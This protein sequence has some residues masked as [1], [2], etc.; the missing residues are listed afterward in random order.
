MPVTV[1]IADPHATDENFEAVFSYFAYVD[2]TFSTYKPTS[3]IMR[4]NRGEIAPADYT[5]DMKEVLELSEKT[6][7][8]TDGFFD[9]R[10]PGGTLDPSGLVKGWAIYH[11][12]KLL[13]LRGIST[14]FIDAG[15]D[16]QAEGN[17]WKIGIKNPLNEVEIV[18]VLYIKDRGVAT[19]G[20]YI[21]GH[22]IYDPRQGGAPVNDIVSLTVIGP[23]VYEA[24]RFATAAFAMGRK[25][26]DFIDNLKGFEGYMINT[27]G[28]AVMT[29]GFEAYVQ[30]N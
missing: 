14:F 26:I 4:I 18:K 11:A 1:E 15:G 6:K 22:H 12:A 8:E 7:R 20:T 9:I 23:N 2:E 16:I 5:D 28:I 27:A 30:K 17:V 29:S 25:G 24:D 19:S 13:R 21:R 10:T 3:E